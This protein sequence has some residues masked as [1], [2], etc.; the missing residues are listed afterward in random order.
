MAG[1]LSNTEEFNITAER[2]DYANG[3]YFFNITLNIKNSKISGIEFKTD[4][5]D[6]LKDMCHELEKKIKGLEREEAL[7]ITVSDFYPHKD[8]GREYAEELLLTFIEALSYW[9]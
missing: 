5:Y 4:N 9:E 6:F 8:E 7:K 2:A 3:K 1:K